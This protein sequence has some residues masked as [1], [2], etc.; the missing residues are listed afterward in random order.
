METGAV[1]SV[2]QKEKTAGKTRRKP[3]GNLVP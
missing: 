1:F 3:T 2:V